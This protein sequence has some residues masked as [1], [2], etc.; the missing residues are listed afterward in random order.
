MN[1]IISGIIRFIITLAIILL[2]YFMVF[3]VF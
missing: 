2:I 1:K 3:R